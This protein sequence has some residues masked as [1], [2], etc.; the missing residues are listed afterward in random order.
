MMRRIKM[1]FFN[2]LVQKKYYSNMG[3]IFGLD[4]IIY[5]NNT[6]KIIKN[7]GKKKLLLKRYFYRITTRLRYS[8]FIFK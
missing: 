8:I 1:K 5:E 2:F 3:V 7:A 4:G 6:E